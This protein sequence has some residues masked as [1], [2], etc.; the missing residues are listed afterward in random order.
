MVRKAVSK[1]ARAQTGLALIEFAFILPLLLFLLLSSVELLRYLRLERQVT[2]AASSIAAMIAQR[3]VGDSR[4]LNFEFDALQVH[5]PASAVDK[6]FGFYNNV[7]I[8][9]TSIVFAPEVPGCLKNCY[10]LGYVAW[11][12]PRYVVGPGIDH[13]L[14]HC[15]TIGIGTASNT[16]PDSLF[17]P[18]SIIVVDLSYNFVPLF[19]SKFIPGIKFYRS[20]Y[21][22]A[23]FATPYVTVPATDWEGNKVYCPGFG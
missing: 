3:Q 22:N 2:L 23:R 10:Y 16:I 20:G 12:W 7:G 6:G 13:M 1:F 11:V 14:R 8:Q 17:G 9:A 15:E 5:F 21:A 19:G 4:L 18:G